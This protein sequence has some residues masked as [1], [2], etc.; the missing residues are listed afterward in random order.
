MQQIL[1]IIIYNL[2]NLWKKVCEICCI[3]ER[4]QV[5]P[6]GARAPL[7]LRKKKYKYIYIYIFI[8]LYILIPRHIAQHHI[9]T[10][11]HDAHQVKLRRM[12]TEWLLKIKEEVTK[13][14]NVGFIKL[15]YQ[16]EWI[17]NVV[18]IPKKDRKVRMQIGRAHV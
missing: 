7:V 6:K 14:L 2:N 16:A 10:C 13:Q 9:D 11:S 12:T 18:P 1:I 4:N 15:V 5:G 8:Y 3:Q 17:V